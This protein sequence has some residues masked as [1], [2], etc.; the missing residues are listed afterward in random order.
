M[1]K[2]YPDQYDEELRMPMNFVEATKAYQNLEGCSLT[3][4]YRTNRV[5]LMTLWN[6][7]Q[8]DA[9]ALISISSMDRTVGEWIKQLGIAQDHALC[10]IH[11]AHEN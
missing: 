10:Q 3:L 9:W 2:F 1:K 11:A 5:R 8:G 4:L 6:F 7:D